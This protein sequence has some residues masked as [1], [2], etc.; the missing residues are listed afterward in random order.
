MVKTGFLLLFSLTLFVFDVRVQGN[1]S[2]KLD[3]MTIR[4]PVTGS[5]QCQD[6]LKCP[7]GEGL[8]VNCGDVITPSTPVQC[9][10]CVLGETFSASFNAAA[11]EDCE[12]CGE[13]RET[14]K[15]CTVTSKAKCGRCKPG[16]Y[17]EG[18]LGLCKPC[19]PCCNDGNDIIIPECQVSGVL[20]GMQCSYLRSDKC[21]ALMTSSMSTMQSTPLPD[22][23]TTSW[24]PS[25]STISTE[26]IS[27]SSEPVSSLIGDAPPNIGIIAGSFVGGLFVVITIFVI[28]CHKVMRKRRKAPSIRIGV[29]TVENRA[30]QAQNHQHGNN[31]IQTGDRFSLPPEVPYEESPLP[32]PIQEEAGDNNPKKIGMQETASP[33]SRQ[34]CLDSKFDGSV[35]KQCTESSKKRAYSPPNVVTRKTTITMSKVTDEEVTPFENSNQLL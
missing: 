28:A 17:A 11:C 7:P 21:S 10:P 24:R 15:T 34:S 33:L 20:T 2:C 35:M 31:K 9:K 27:S 32:L 6:C 22:Q 5:I 14:T 4:D 25:P 18:M 29:V 23:S 13:Y 3:Q 12:N 26:V 8:S 1:S 16:A 19:S 30:G